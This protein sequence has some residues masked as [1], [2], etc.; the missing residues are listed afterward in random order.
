MYQLNVLQRNIYVRLIIKCIRPYDKWSTFLNA[1][2]R[3]HLKDC[4]FFIGLIGI[5]NVKHASKY[6]GNIGFKRVS[7]F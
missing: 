4:L 6:D 1:R 3:Y 2:E 5:I 7:I